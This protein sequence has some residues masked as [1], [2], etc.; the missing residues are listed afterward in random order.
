MARL[1]SLLCSSA[2]MLLASLPA[3][4]QDPVSYTLKLAAGP[5]GGGLLSPLGRAGYTFGADFELA[6][7][8]SQ[9]SHFV[10]GLG[11]RAFPGDFVNV[12]FIPYTYAATGVNP[13]IY[14]TRVRK[15][16]GQGFQLTG[17]YRGAVKRWE[18]AYW[19]G[20]LRI[21]ANKLSETDTGTQLVT[22]GRASTVSGNV[23]AVN[24]IVSI[25]EKKT[26]SVGPMLGVGYEFNGYTLEVN[27]WAAS[28]ESPTLGKKSGVA[29]ELAFGF[30]F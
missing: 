8:R 10:L 24:T 5:A 2:L 18:G 11:W 15:P 28:M 23:L 25:R 29:T 7:E 3:V 1:R 20:G 6:Y 19:Q 30:R 13:T 22:D 21:G 26:L 12:S 4:A 16:E 14:E 9:G 27:A 17:L